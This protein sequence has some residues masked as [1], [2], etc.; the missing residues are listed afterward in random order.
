M[1]AIIKIAACFAGLALSGSAAAQILSYTESTNSSTELALGYPVP[2]PVDSLT[3]VAGFRAY[4]SLHAQHQ[5]L[6]FSNAD[7]VAGQIVGTTRQG[8]DI[9]AYRLGDIDTINVNGQ[10]EAAALINGT[11]HAREWASPEVVTE[12][13]EQLVEGKNDAGLIQ[14]ILE[15]MNTVIVPVNNVDGLLQT[16][17]YPTQVTPTPTGQPTT[18]SPPQFESPRDGRMR[19]K[20]MLDVDEALTTAAD[21]LLGVD[22]NRNNAQFFSNGRNSPNPESIVYRGVAPASEPEIQ[23]LQQA[24]ALAPVDRLRWFVDTHSFSRVFFVPMPP[25]PR[26]NTNTTRLVNR[27]SAATGTNPNHPAYF[28]ILNQPGSGISGTAEFYAYTHNIP[29]WTLEIEPPQGFAGIP[30]GGAYYGG[31]G[32]SHDG[33]IL[34]DSEIERA[35][36]EL[37][38]ANILGLYHQAGPPAALAAEIRDTADNVVYAAEWQNNGDGTRTLVET[39]STALMADGS[40]YSLWLAFDKPMRFINSVD[41]IVEYP[42]QSAIGTRPIATITGSTNQSPAQSFQVPVTFGANAWPLAPGGAPSGYLRYRAD[43]VTGTFLMPD[44]LQIADGTRITLEVLVTDLGGLLNDGDPSTVVDF[45]NGGWTGYED[46]NGVTGD[47]GGTDRSFTPSANRNPDLPPPPPP[48]GG[49]GGGGVIT[50]AF[51][52][53]LVWITLLVACGN[54]VRAHSRARLKSFESR[55]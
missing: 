16:Q 19:R 54:A 50:P 44:D 40:Q 52:L 49:G 31:F 1:A 36:D 37:T 4:D 23:A 22:L 8:R 43:A 24:A 27:L 18:T 30:N 20:N 11:I 45:A 21:R 3:A 48:S 55:S 15:N 7:V 38:V 34:P 13:I 33:F 5:D 10:T 29:A 53:V 26:H 32:V 47:T 25:N 28:P 35:R 2:L 51:L 17:R 39:T 9:W 14:Y 41:A 6:M 12:L 42:G 46:G